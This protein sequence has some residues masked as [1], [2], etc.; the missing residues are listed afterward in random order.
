MLE[1]LSTIVYI[2]DAIDDLDEDFINNT[3]NPLLPKYGYTNAHDYLTKNL[4][5]IIPVVNETIGSLQKYYSSVRKK[6]YSNV[7]LCDN[8]V[9]YGIP[10]SAGRIIADR[11][12]TKSN[13]LLYHINRKIQ[14][15]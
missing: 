10:E 2:L 4:Y 1:E 5:D 3:Y 6:M 15:C 14:R 8:V 11:T 13:A 7:S 9:Y 12:S